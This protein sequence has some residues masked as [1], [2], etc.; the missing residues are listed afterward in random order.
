[1]TS[2]DGYH[3]EIQPPACTPR[4]A[5]DFECP[6]VFRLNG[7]FYMVAILGGHNR[8]VYCEKG[9]GA[10]LAAGQPTV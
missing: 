7:K 6:S 9:D 4:N 5:F 8:M 2:S 3:W 10:F 1:M